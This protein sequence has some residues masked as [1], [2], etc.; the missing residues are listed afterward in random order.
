MIDVVL[1][2]NQEMV[3]LLSEVIMDTEE[4][5]FHITPQTYIKLK[6]WLGEEIPEEMQEQIDRYEAEYDSIT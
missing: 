2:R 6:E 3:A 5:E 1:K 4:Y